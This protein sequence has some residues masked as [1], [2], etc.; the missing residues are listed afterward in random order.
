MRIDNVLL[1][2][3]NSN[4]QIK[5]RE[6]DITDDLDL[7]DTLGFDSMSF[8]QMVIDIEEEFAIEIPEEKL[9]IDYMRYYRNL[10]ESVLEKLKESDVPEI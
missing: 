6:D 9:L 10:R 1:N 2:I 3:I 5:L 4:S 8:V 7:V